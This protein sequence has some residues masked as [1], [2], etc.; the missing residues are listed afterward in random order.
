MKVYL[1]HG[2]QSKGDRGFR[3]WLKTGLEKM[4]HEVFAPDLPNA[5]FPSPE[6]WLG[7]LHKNIFISEETVILG[8]SLGGLA[9][10]K[11]LQS[12]PDGKKIKK[13]VLVAPVI[14]DVT[15]ITEQERVEVFLPWKKELLNYKKINN[16]T[17]EGVDAFFS[18]ND[19]YIP[20]ESAQIVKDNLLSR[21][22]VEHDK[23]HYNMSKLSE[24]PLIL[25]AIIK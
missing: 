24:V 14:E 6:K 15:G 21:V 16:S 2:W 22:F 5:D 13:A 4:G 23:G 19:E 12:L 8:H 1:I 17:I 25:N 18:D 20:L 11:F 7:F 9:T 3:S 10:L